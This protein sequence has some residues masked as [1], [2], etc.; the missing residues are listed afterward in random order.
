MCSTLCSAFP[1]GGEGAGEQQHLWS[2]PGC[3][4]LSWALLFTFTPSLL[5]HS[6][7]VHLLS[8]LTDPPI[9]LF[10]KC[11]LLCGG[12]CSSC[13]GFRLSKRDV[14]LPA[15]RFPSSQ[16][17]SVVH[18]IRMKVPCQ[19]TWPLLQRKSKTGKERWGASGIRREG[20]ME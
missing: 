1:E 17:R 4:A 20:D 5:T 8:V 3:Q 10:N 13:R 14:F 2:P 6:F 19:G 18:A 12:H 15:G 9:H 7:G 16:G 11:Y